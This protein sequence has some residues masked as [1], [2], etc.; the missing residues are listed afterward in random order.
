MGGHGSGRWGFHSK[1][2]TVEE[3]LKFSLADI[4]RSCRQPLPEL[5]GRFMALGWT[6]GSSMGYRVQRENNSLLL[7]LEYSV[8]GQARTQKVRISETECNYGGVRYWMH[9]SYCHRRV[10][11]LY[12]V[13]GHF[14]C[15]QCH[16][17]TYTSA[18]EAH[19]YD[20]LRGLLS[21]GI[22][23]LDDAVE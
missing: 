21:T 5:V 7:A 4:T 6:G 3:C 17:L 8:N 13:G 14:A 9:C 12:G 2:R 22:D 19:Y 10:G 1:K 16:D 11:K 20:S 18:Q 23:R 15:R